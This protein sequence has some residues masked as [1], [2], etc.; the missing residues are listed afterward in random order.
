V[1][2]AVGGTFAATIEV[3]AHDVNKR[4][5]LFVFEEMTAPFVDSPYKKART[6]PGDALGFA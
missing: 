2:D 3:S 4:W 1:N 6:C 5:L